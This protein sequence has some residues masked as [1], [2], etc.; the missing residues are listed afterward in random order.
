MHNSVYKLKNLAII[1]DFNLSE[2]FNNMYDHTKLL[3]FLNY[4]IYFIC[5]Y[6]F[7][8]RY[9]KNTMDVNFG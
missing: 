3:F 9:I 4:F 6:F 8:D 7:L 2:D 1:K 5:E